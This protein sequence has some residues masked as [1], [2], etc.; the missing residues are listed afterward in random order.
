[1]FVLVSSIFVMANTMNLRLTLII[2]VPLPLLAI[3]MNMFGKV[4]H[5][6]FRKVQESFADLTRK[7][8]ENISGI[9]IIKAFTQEQAEIKNFAR[10]NERNYRINMKLVRARGLFSPLITLIASFSYLL[11]I[12]FGAPMVIQEKITL[13]DFIAYNSYIGMLIHPIAFIGM[14]INQLQQAG[15]SLD[16]VEEL[17]AEKPGI[18]DSK[19]ARENPGPVRRLSFHDRNETQRRQLHKTRHRGFPG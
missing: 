16:R 1:M 9:R 12:F 6:R 3:I 10:M 4:I 11:L 18:S 19:E 8:Q 13:G 5:K 15:A 2:F 17:F 14:I 7:T